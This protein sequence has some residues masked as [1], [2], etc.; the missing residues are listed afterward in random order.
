M[1]RKTWRFVAA[2]ALMAGLVGLPTTAGAATPGIVGRAGD[3]HI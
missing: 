3:L 2:T 1:P